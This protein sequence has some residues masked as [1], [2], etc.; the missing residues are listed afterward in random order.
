[1]E[2]EGREEGGAGGE[3]GGEG[4]EEGGEE[5]W[6]NVSARRS[7]EV[8][9]RGDG[10][11]TARR[12]VVMSDARATRATSDGSRGGV[13]SVERVSIGDAVR[14]VRRASRVVSAEFETTRNALRGRFLTLAR[15]RRSS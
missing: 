12:C 11:E 14:C 2:G 3:A 5:G 9:R 4:R 8:E 15:V 7:S 6:G 10:E 13:R 1:M